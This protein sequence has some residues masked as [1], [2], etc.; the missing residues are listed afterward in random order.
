M[1]RAY[2]ILTVNPLP[3]LIQKTAG[4][5]NNLTLLYVN[6]VWEHKPIHESKSLLQYTVISIN[7]TQRQ[8]TLQQ[9]SL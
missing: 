5:Q 6:K 4:T 7:A 3:D 1:Q 8:L 2:N 9:M